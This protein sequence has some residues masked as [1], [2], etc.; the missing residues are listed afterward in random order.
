MWLSPKVF[1]WRAEIDGSYCNEPTLYKRP[2]EIWKHAERI[3]NRQA[4]HFQRVDAICAL[5]RAVNS[6][7]NTL[8][9]EYKFNLI[10]LSDVPKKPLQQL[11][12]FGII[13]PFILNKLIDIRNQIEHEDMNPPTLVQCREFLD[14]S[15]YF[16]KATDSYVHYITDGY[17]LI[18]ESND[19]TEAVSLRMETSPEKNWD[20]EISI[21]LPDESPYISKELRDGWLQLSNA[22]KCG[23]YTIAPGGFHKGIYE[24]YFTA[25]H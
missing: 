1:Q 22:S 5:K 6:R 14:V 24:A 21:W 20:L 15:W 18:L 13:R 12:Y 3:L 16:L 19:E 17:C 2:Y 11:E 8:Q 10:P 23:L 9:N 4:N 25:I 7:L